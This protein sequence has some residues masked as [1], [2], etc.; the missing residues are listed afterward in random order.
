MGPVRISTP[1]SAGFGEALPGAALAVAAVGARGAGRGRSDAAEPAADNAFPGPGRAGNPLRSGKGEEAGVA[2][3]AVAGA[4]GAGPAVDGVGPAVVGAEGAGPTVA[5]GAGPSVTVAE[6]AAM[7]AIA[8]VALEAPAGA[9]ARGADVSLTAVA[10]PIDPTMSAAIATTKRTPRDGLTAFTD[11]V[12]N[13]A[14]VTPAAGRAVPDV[15]VPI[16]PS[17]ARVDGPRAASWLDPGARALSP[18]ANARASDSSEAREKRRD[19]SRSSARK[20][21]ASNAGGRPGTVTDGVGTGEVQIFTSRS[22]TLSPSKGRT[23][24]THLCAMTPSDHRSER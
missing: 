3:P 1:D 24:V 16:A 12:V 6:G 17:A 10:T 18:A 4:E 11:A 5:E 7:A 21:H 15:L 13:G 14:E 8:I 9:S 20:N 22:P 23:P 2:G 19:G